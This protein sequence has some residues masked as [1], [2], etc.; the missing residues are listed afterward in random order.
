MT[1]ATIFAALRLP[2]GVLSSLESG[3]ITA[4]YAQS[5]N[6]PKQDFALCSDEPEASEVKI[7]AWARCER[8]QQFSEKDKCDILA[9]RLQVPIEILQNAIEQNGFIWLSYLRVYHLPSPIVIKNSIKGVFIALENRIY[10]NK[11]QPVLDDI[12]YEKRKREV[13]NLEPPEPLDVQIQKMLEEVGLQRKMESS[14]QLDWVESI[15]SLGTTTTG[16]NYE[17]GTAF[18]QIV[19]RSLTFLGFEL[20]PKAKGGAGG[21]DLCCIKPYLLVGECKS[22][23]SIPGNTV[24]ELH[25]LGNVH[26]TRNIFDS[27]VKLIIGPGRPTDQLK[28]SSQEYKISIIN[29][30]TLQK[31]VELKAKYDGAIDLFELK[32][33][34]QAGQIDNKIDEYIQKVESE[35]ELRSQ[36]IQAVKKLAHMGTTHP[37]V[38][39]ICTQYNAMFFTG[40][41]SVLQDPIVRDLL[42]ELSSPLAGYLGRVEEAGKKCD[43]FYYLR[44]LPIENEKLN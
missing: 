36:I 12:T 35:I 37:N 39:R 38:E 7:S 29:P 25:K 17:K 26:L 27:A 6:R 1:E 8:S 14:K 22:G 4:I 23:L 18:E 40:N 31:L 30:M 11:M 21:M 9:A 44:D 2:T 32:K 19:Q 43:R 10:I 13:E 41:E 15:N 33:Y 28:R 20:D 16:G 34:L 42:I 5:F 24:Y 3:S